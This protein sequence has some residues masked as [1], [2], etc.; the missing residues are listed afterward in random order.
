DLS[1]KGEIA[2]TAAYRRHG[3]LGG[4][5]RDVLEHVAPAQSTLSIG[6]VASVFDELARTSAAAGRLH[7]LQ[8]LLRRATALEAKYIVKIISGDLRIGLRESLVEEAIA[9]A[10]DETLKDVQRA[11]MLLGDIKGALRLAAEHRLQEAK[12]RLFH[13]IGFMLA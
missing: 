4:A 9:K 6:E 2:L 11:N 13:P 5:A 8:Q 1:G 3:D 12:M 7:F 10:Y